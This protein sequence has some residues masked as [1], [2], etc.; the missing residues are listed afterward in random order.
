MLPPCGNKQYFV[1][2]EIFKVSSEKRY[3]KCCQL[4]VMLA[5]ITD[6]SHFACIT[7]YFKSL[8]GD[9]DLPYLAFWVQG[10]DVYYNQTFVTCPKMKRINDIAW[11][12]GDVPNNA[13][14]DER[15]AQLWVHPSGTGLEDIHCEN[16]LNRYICEVDI[17]KPKT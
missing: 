5:Q 17:A 4:G 12:H 11:K 16:R 2:K 14:N 6:R 9:K 13:N 8:Y 10:E 15:C 3:S 7:A 1:S